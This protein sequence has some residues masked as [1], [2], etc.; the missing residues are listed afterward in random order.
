[1]SII[2]NENKIEIKALTTGGLKPEAIAKQLKL[3]Y[4][5]VK[6][7]MYRQKLVADL[8]PKVIVQKDY[9]K[10]RV[11]GIIRRYI[12]DYPLARLDDIMAAC[13][14]TCHKTTL[15]RYLNNNGLGR[16]NAKRN[17]L[18]RN[19]NRTKRIAFCTQML[20]RTDEE[21]KRILW[22]DETMMKAFPNGE[23]VFY[24]A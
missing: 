22:T 5:T 4:E 12:E 1:M 14:L 17:I 3:K 21:L 15:A 6:K 2:L 10:G 7:H 19:A 8:P 24:R 13:E 16:T 9:F 18:L 20:Q 11:P 23:A